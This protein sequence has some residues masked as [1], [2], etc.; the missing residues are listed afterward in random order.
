MVKAKLDQ[1]SRF[2]LVALHQIFQHQ[3]LPAKVT[4]VN[5]HWM[6]DHNDQPSQDSQKIHVMR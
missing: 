4:S 1:V 6:F 5:P 2:L 3:F